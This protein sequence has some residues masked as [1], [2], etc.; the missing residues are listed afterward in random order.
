MKL[1]KKLFSN[2]MI[3]NEFFRKQLMFIQRNQT[4]HQPGV[5]VITVN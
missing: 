3:S 2:K 1:F 4:G 5:L